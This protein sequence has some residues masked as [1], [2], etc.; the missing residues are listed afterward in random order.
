MRLDRHGALL[1]ISG[2][3]FISDRIFKFLAPHFP[4]NALSLSDNLAGAGFFLNPKLL[5]ITLPPF[6]SFGGA[7]A[8]MILF[9]IFATEQKLDRPPFY[10]ILAGGASNLTDRALYSGVID[11]IRI[12]NI[13]L[14]IADLLVWVGILLLLRRSLFSRRSSPGIMS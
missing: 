13:T 11:Y 1:W 7:L 6:F 10:L 4:E 5:G 2:L 3:F 9:F 8:A 14:N 12:G